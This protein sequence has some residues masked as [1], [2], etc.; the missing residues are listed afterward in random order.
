M[1][2]GLFGI[3][4]S[5][6]KDD[7]HWSKNCFNSSFPA[8]LAC[9]MMEKD[10]PAIYA[11]LAPKNRKLCVVCDEIPIRQ[12]FNCGNLTTNDLEFDFESKFEPYQKYAFDSIDGIDLV[13]KD[14]NG[15]Y[16]API[17]VKLTVL[18]TSATSKKDPSKWGCEIVIRTA[19]TSY[20]A[21][22]IWDAV[23]KYAPQVREIFEQPCSNIGSWTND[24]EMAH[25]TSTLCKALDDFE[26]QYY[27]LQRPLVMEP[28]WKTEGQAPLLNNNAFDIVVWSDFAF[29]RL[30]IDAS[31]PESDIMSRPMRAT[32]RMARCIWEL[33]KSGKINI[34]EIYR[35]IA[36]GTQTDKELSVPGDKW[37]TYITTNR[38]LNPVIPKTALSEIISPGYI[39]NLRPE[40]RFDQT[41]YFNYASIRHSK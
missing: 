39:D 41:L 34:Q 8:S 31:Y 10:I 26:F 38:V 32:A 29:S 23:H 18:P 2:S 1:A 3:I 30:F 36:F 16:L 20:C 19:T 22:G 4:H 15:N 33:S 21:L 25:K 35:E 7:Q 9:Y 14:L 12:L 6:R 28:L 17:E 13:V 5:N 11:R 40:R 27:N 37:R 24:F